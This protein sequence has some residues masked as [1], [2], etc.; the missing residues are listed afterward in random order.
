MGM[1]SGQYGMAPALI[2]SLEP[3]ALERAV[4]RLPAAVYKNRDSQGPVL[5]AGPDQVPAVGAVKEGGLAERDGQIVVRRGN[6]FEP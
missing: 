5:G 4:S 1:E 3:G 6:T 2:G